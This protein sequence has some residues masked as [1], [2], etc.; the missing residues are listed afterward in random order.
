MVGSQNYLIFRHLIGGAGHPPNLLVKWADSSDCG[1]CLWGSAD[2]V[3][4]RDISELKTPK[5]RS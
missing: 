3:I 2:V 1:R 5:L 4:N